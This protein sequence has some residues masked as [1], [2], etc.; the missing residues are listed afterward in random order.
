MVTS[1]HFPVFH[2]QPSYINQSFCV[3]VFTSDEYWTLERLTPHATNMSVVNI[4]DVDRETVIEALR[5]YRKRFYNEEIPQ[6]I[7]DQVFAKVGG[8]LIFLNQ[9]SKAKDMLATCEHINRREKAWFLNKCW[10]L[11]DSMDD[12]VEEQ[13]KFCVRLFPLGC[14]TIC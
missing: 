7:L 12:D 5:K 11:G 2:Y 13:Q 1:K 14:L 10:I 3:A 4:H 8:R 9:V 6:G